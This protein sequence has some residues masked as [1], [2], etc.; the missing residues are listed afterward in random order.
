MLVGRSYKDELKYLFIFYLRTDST[1]VLVAGGFKLA[2]ST[3]VLIILECML[4]SSFYPP[5]PNTL[6]YLPI[7]M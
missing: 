4:N 1:N 5:E 7:S 2:T 6:V 3:F